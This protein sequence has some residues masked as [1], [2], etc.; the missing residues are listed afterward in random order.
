MDQV[1]DWQ[2]AETVEM[3]AGGEVAPVRVA[4]PA[5]SVVEL[6]P[7]E[8]MAVQAQVFLPA[9]QTTALPMQC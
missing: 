2:L 3:A 4:L 1:P 7:K 8:Q 6:L 5:Q 9:L